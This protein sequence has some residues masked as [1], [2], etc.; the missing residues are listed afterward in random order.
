MD[1]G[2]RVTLNTDN[3]LITDTTMTDEYLLADTHY[4]LIPRE[5]L[6]LVM[7]GIKSAF[8]PYE[9]KRDQIRRVKDRVK[10]LLV[11]HVAKQGPEQEHGNR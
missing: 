9:Y 5:V 3:R 11:E 6:D 4:D 2:L 7:A 1:L 10:Q 8:I